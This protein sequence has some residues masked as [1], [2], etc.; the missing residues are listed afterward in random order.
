MP[1]VPALTF[2]TGLHTLVD[3][4]GVKDRNTDGW[5][6]NPYLRDMWRKEKRGRNK[7]NKEPKAIVNTCDVRE[8]EED[9]TTTGEGEFSEHSHLQQTALVYG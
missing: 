4:F 7:G 8:L 1:S 2:N 9:T 5:K 3:I 6:F